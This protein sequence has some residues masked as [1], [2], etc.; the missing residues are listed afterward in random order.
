MPESWRRPAWFATACALL[1]LGGCGGGADPSSVTAVVAPLHAAQAGADPGVTWNLAIAAPRIWHSLSMNPAGDVIVA[2]EAGGPLHVSSDGGSTWTTGNS[3][4]AMWISS[5]MT[6]SGDHLFAV[7]YEGDLVDS[8]DHGQTWRA[9]ASSPLVYSPSGLGFQSVAVSQDGQRIAAVIQNGSIVFSSDGGVTWRAG[10][11]PDGPQNR[12][13]RSIDSTPDGEVLVAVSHNGEIYRSTDAANS[14]RAV[15]VTVAGSS[16]PVIEHWYRVKLSADGLTVAVVAN[17]V[18]GGPG[19]GIYVSRDGGATWAKGYS[20]VADYT[21]LVM[22][23]DGQVIAASVSDTKGKTGRV[24]LSTDQGANFE[25]VSMPATD[26]NWRAIAMSPN[27]DRVAAATGSFHTETT[28]LLY[29]GQRL[30]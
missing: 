28:G 6:A 24:L 27:A 17:S 26:T 20:Q 2:G 12:W 3:S 25:P 1:Y 13:W 14:W 21:F 29:T 30:R 22:T 18:G 10:V 19:T 15:S 9:V 23:A 8:T 16:T 11:L 7:Q 5:A 4:N